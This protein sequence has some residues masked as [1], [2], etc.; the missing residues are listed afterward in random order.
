MGK[1]HPLTFTFPEALAGLLEAFDYRPRGLAASGEACPSAPGAGPPSAPDLPLPGGAPCSPSFHRGPPPPLSSPHGCLRGPV[2]ASSR[3]CPVLRSH[4]SA[5]TTGTW[6]RREL[7][8]WPRLTLCGSSSLSG[9]PPVRSFAFALTPG[10][11]A[12]FVSAAIAERW[13]VPW[14]DSAGGLLSLRL[15]CRGVWQLMSSVCHGRHS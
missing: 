11:R 6:P 7:V 4:L 10:R 5:G 14:A 1:C 3:P 9:V 12:G 13:L 15:C 8:S 2:S